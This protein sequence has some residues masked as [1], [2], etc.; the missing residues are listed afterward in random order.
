DPAVREACR[1]CLPGQSDDVVRRHVRFQ[2]ERKLEHWALLLHQIAIRLRTAVAEELPYIA[3][4]LNLIKVQISNDDFFF[5]ARSFGNDFSPRCAEVPLA[6]KLTDVP[7]V[8]TSNAID[9]S[10]KVTIS[11]GMRGLFE[12]PKILAQAR[13][14]SRRIEYDFRSV[15]TQSPCAFREVTIVANVNADV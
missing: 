14:S 5:V 10:D 9:R 13:H 15:Q 7:W 4:F 8:F 1:F 2:C 12:F 3:H 11:D 6:I